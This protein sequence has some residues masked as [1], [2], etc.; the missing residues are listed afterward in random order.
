MR[1]AFGTYDDVLAVPRGP[2]G[3]FVDKI[4]TE[5][6]ANL[7]ASGRLQAIYRKIH[8]PYDPWQP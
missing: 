4:L 1:E 2:R 5:A 3:D 8:L 7:S 6:L